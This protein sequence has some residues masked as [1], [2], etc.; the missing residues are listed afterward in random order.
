[1]NARCL[2]SD[3]LDAITIATDMIRRI[4]EATL[5]KASVS[6]RILV[7][8]DTCSPLRGTT[9]KPAASAAAGSGSRKGAEGGGGGELEAVLEPDCEDNAAGVASMLASAGTNVMLITYEDVIEA[10]ASASAS[11]SGGAGAA[12]RG[13]GS[14]KS[15]S[16]ASSASSYTGMLPLAERRAS[17]AALRAFLDTHLLQP[18][19]GVAHSVTDAVHAFSLLR[20]RTVNQV[21][22]FRGDLDIGGEVKI[23]VWTYGH[24]V[25][26]KPDSLKRIPM[27]LAATVS[28]RQ[29][30]GEVVNIKGEWRPRGRSVDRSV[31]SAPA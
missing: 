12:S 17:Y 29:D 30:R 26:A 20:T 2:Q 9:F 10:A 16:S 3:I 5:S 27:S 4:G 13:G 24:T 1:M 7:I 19:G 6:S 25:E 23:P 22:K 11:A 21:T 8:T 31:R 28:E 15:S 14:S 18:T